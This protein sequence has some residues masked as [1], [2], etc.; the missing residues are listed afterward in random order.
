ML[1]VKSLIIQYF[2]MCLKGARDFFWDPT[3]IL[4][5]PKVPLTTT[6][7]DICARDIFKTPVTIFKN[8]PVT[9]K[10]CP[11]QI[12]KFECHGHYC[13]SRGKTLLLRNASLQR[14]SVILGIRLS[15]WAN[16]SPNFKAAFLLRCSIFLNSM[17]VDSL[18][19]TAQQPLPPSTFYTLSSLFKLR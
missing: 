7:C 10:N 18:S 17:S 6:V 3:H 11:L 16:F 15:N 14:K 9:W 4:K 1:F 5:N 19:N 13:M 8:V 12:S 2:I